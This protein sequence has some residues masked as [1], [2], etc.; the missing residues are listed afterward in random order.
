MVATLGPVTES[1]FAL[2]LLTRSGN[3]AFGRW[4]KRVRSDLAHRLSAVE[5]LVEEYRPVPDL[6]WILKGRHGWDGRQQMIDEHLRPRL[7]SSVFEFCQTAVMP[8]WSAA[9]SHLEAEREIRG[10]VVIANGVERLLSS[11]HPRLRWNPPVLEIHQEPEQDVY[12]NGRGLLLSP[13]LFLSDH[14][15]AFIDVERESG[16]PALAFAIP[17]DE[18]MA[19]ELWSSSEPKELALGALVGH[20]RAA[21]LQ[22]LTESCTTGEL[23]QRLGISLAGASKHAK[24]LR[25]AGL[26]TTARN[27][28][29]ALHTLTSLGVALLQP[30]RQKEYG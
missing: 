9:R 27:R 28:N 10:R 20:T 6:L 3:V 25:K 13:S 12:L 24:V 5:Q 11:L 8:Y 2:Q 4:R 14:A 22:V 17:V 21:A 16:L 18:A 1:I 29:T 7:T 26:I 30:K 23:S 19:T 15:F